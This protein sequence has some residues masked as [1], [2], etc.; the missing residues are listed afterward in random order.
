MSLPQPATAFE[1]VEA[2]LYAGIAS[3]G[4]LAAL[5]LGLFGHLEN[6]ELDL[7]QLAAKTGTRPERLEPL[8]EL[9]ASRGLLVKER[10]YANTPTASE[11]LVQGKPLYQGHALAL[12]ASFMASLEKDLAGTLGRD[13][14]ALDVFEACWSLDSVMEG[15]A[16]YARTGALQRVTRFLVGLPGFSDMRTLCD[17]GGN[18]GEFSMALLDANPNLR[19]VI[20]DLPHVAEASLQRCRQ[21]GY[22]ERIEAWAFDLRV[23]SPAQDAYDVILVSHVL[24]G[25][26]GDLAPVVGRLAA[27]LRPGGW[28][29]SHHFAPGGREAGV[30]A[31]HEL[32]TR[33]AGYPTHFL[34]RHRLEQPMAAHGLGDFLADLPEAPLGGGLILAGRKPA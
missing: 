1:P 4:L 3:K 23:D 14:K 33:L 8:L 24:Y 20:L 11:Y 13:D 15:T 22:G 19:A 12:N 18:H 5:E 21:R 25:A 9:L 30:E 16:A 28:L 6:G 34:A 10:G 31:C 27:A 2:L 26:A 7:E 29:V 17:V 32:I